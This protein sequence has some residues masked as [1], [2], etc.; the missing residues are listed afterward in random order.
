MIPTEKRNF[1]LKRLHSLTGLALCGF[2]LEHIFTN[3]AAIKAYF[4]DTLTASETFNAHVA[5][6]HS[7]PALPLVEIM[8]LAAPFL[9]HTIYG[10]VLT[11]RGS[12]NTGDYPYER[13]FMY[14]MQR[15]SAVII[16]IF[17]VVHVLELRFG[18]NMMPRPPE[19]VVK[20]STND[21][22]HRYSVIIERYQEGVVNEAGTGT[23]VEHRDYWAHTAEYFRNMPQWGIW[24]YIL[25]VVSTAF[26]FGNGLFLAGITWGIWIRRESQTTAFLACMGLACAVGI[27][28]VLSILGFTVNPGV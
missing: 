4:G 15:V 2:I 23:R 27:A 26:H 22:T 14:L 16:T 3:S 20:V 1:Y 21:T 11:A 28:G 12:F 6:L 5:F 19:A 7:I 9:F 10:F 13:N 25:G 17:L 8:F 18:V 24:L